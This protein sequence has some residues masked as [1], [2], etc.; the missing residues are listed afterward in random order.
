MFEE[1]KLQQLRDFNNRLISAKKLSKDLRLSILEKLRF[2][3]LE[4]YSASEHLTRWG[5]LNFISQFNSQLHVD[6]LIQGNYTEQQAISIFEKCSDKLGCLFVDNSKIFP[7]RILQLKDEETYVKVKS[8]SVEDENS[9]V[10]VY[11]QRGPGTIYDS[12]MMQLLST[13]MEEP[14]FDILRTKKQLGYTVYCQD[15]ST[16]GILGLSVNVQTQKSKF[17]VEEATKDIMQFL[18]QD[19]KE[20]LYGWTVEEFQEQV[21]ALITIKTNEDCQLSEEVSRNWDEIVVGDCNFDRLQQEVKYLRNVTFD[22]MKKFYEEICVVNQR[23]LVVQVEGNYPLSVHCTDDI[24]ATITAPILDLT[25]L[26]PEQSQANQA[27]IKSLNDYVDSS[28]FYP[29]SFVR[30]S[31]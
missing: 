12:I 8:L 7:E 17:T 1:E 22:E 11:I 29:V 19:F 3:L 15:H 20:L 18:R 5:L 31:V 16:S 2:P 27:H 25:Y 26:T 14:C 30:D 13:L 9:M 24:T 21:D 6:C 28:Y 10:T 23:I 4:K